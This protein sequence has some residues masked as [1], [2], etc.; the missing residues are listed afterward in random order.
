MKVEIIK[1]ESGRAIGYRMI[2]ESS[3]NPEILETISALHYWGKKEGN[4]KGD[5]QY[6]ERVSEKGTD[7]TSEIV[8][9]R[10]EVKKKKSC[11]KC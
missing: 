7:N 5:V 6:A 9:L 8:F 2:R 11:E 1:N 10:K 3:D 4:V